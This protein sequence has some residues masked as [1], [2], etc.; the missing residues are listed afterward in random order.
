[1]R[2]GQVN[3]ENYKDFLK[4][5]GVKNPKGLEK[6]NGEGNGKKADGQNYY[7]SDEE[8]IALAV[9]AGLILEGMGGRDGDDSY[10][11]IVDVSDSVR[12][13]I[14]NHVR[15]VFIANSNGSISASQGDE[16]GA[17]IKDYLKT[18]P[19]S[20]R[21]SASWTLQQIGREEAERIN[22]YIKSQSPGW[23]TTQSFNTK[24]LTESNF[25]LNHMDVKA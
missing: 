1:M 4:I 7:R 9:K 17:I 25:G 20:E 16:R 24:I 22:D 19:P 23:S 15:Q 6:L 18:L 5:L 14:I 11:K 21:L 8:S 12:E 2:I 3:Q 13:K 10:K